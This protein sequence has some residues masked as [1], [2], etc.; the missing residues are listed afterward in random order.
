MHA[1]VFAAEAHSTLDA[2]V[3]AGFLSMLSEL[4]A[5]GEP[6]AAARAGDAL[7]VHL[8]GGRTGFVVV[9]YPVKTVVVAGFAEHVADGVRGPWIV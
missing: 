1:A 3:V 9:V 7:V 6:F 4:V 8:G 2:A 5:V